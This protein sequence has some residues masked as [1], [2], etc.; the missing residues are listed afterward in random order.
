MSVV[1]PGEPRCPSEESIVAFVGGHLDALASSRIEVHVDACAACRRQL[2]EAGRALV[3]SAAAAPPDAGP[4]PLPAASEG[5]PPAR[6]RPGDRVGRYL[7]LDVLGEGAMGVVFSALDPELARH[8]ALKLVRVAH[9]HGA[10]REEHEARLIREAQ[11]M[12]RLSHPNVVRVYDIGAVASG[13]WIAMEHVR[14]QTLRAWLAAEPRPWRVALAAFLQAGDGLAAAHA[15]D[16]VH[17]DFKPDNVLVAD[18]G[19]VLVTDF[20]LA[21]V[22]E[23]EL[24]GAGAGLTTSDLTRTRAGTLVGTPAYMAPEQLSAHA[25]EVD[26]RADVFAFGVALYEALFGERPY[27]AT[28]LGELERALARGVPREPPRRSEVPRWVRRA[29][30]SALVADRERRV[31]SMSALLHALRAD[32]RRR[33]VRVVLPVT[34]LVVLAGGVALAQHLASAPGRACRASVERADGVWGSE[35]RAAGRAAFTATGLVYADEA[36]TRASA[37]LDD[38]LGAW[39]RERVAACDATH[40]QA[41]QSEALLDLRLH[42]LDQRLDEARALADAFTR[43]DATTVQ[44]ASEAVARLAESAICG[45]LERLRARVPPPTDPDASALVD[46]AEA[47]LAEAEIA[48]LTGD[49]ARGMSLAKE[50][51]ALAEQAAHTPTVAAAT[52]LLAR[53]TRSSGDAIGAMPLFGDAIWSAVAAGD[54]RVAANAAVQF[55]RSKLEI[56]HDRDESLGWS[57]LAEAHIARLGGDAT[58]NLQLLATR[59]KLILEPGDAADRLIAG[60]EDAIAE[61]AQVPSPTLDAALL[62]GLMGIGTLCREIECFSRAVTALEQ[63]VAHAD[64]HLGPLHPGTLAAKIELG[65]T[66]STAGRYAPASALLSSLQADLGRVYPEGHIDSAVLLDGLGRAMVGLG[67]FD[68]ATAA[69]EAEVA[70][71]GKVLGG[72]LGVLAFAYQ[73]HAR[74]SIGAGRGDAALIAIARA[75]SYTTK[76]LGDDATVRRTSATLRALALEA[77][78]RFDE[79]RAAF[80]ALEADVRGGLRSELAAVLGGMGRSDARAGRLEQAIARQREALA[81]RESVYGFDNPEIVIALRDLGAVYLDAGR[82]DEA[83]QALERGLGI[84]DAAPHDPL[85]EGELSAHLAGVVRASDPTRAESLL[86]AAERIAVASVYPRGARLARLVAARRAP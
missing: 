22:A 70:E 33:L 20:G 19:R 47:L 82:L 73:S 52:L 80:E 42:C 26:H 39:R 81:L 13:V 2:L 84:L 61:R 86:R 57:R 85:L 31:R 15:A 76:F 12:A 53:A 66:L 50:A 41:T 32:P 77:A 67:R 59:A 7:I 48:D 18:D 5:P 64:P 16:I 63:A 4:A 38:H 79:A 1:G 62:D 3:E 44:R 24:P 28:T 37:A 60:L 72:E 27:A 65:L 14:G 78:E 51:L 58:L 10:G 54:D 11:A 40:D 8:V 25:G 21:R 49:A 83:R 17:R 55:S 43:A 6:L 9:H 69:H 23:V 68:E 71:F 74:A 75:E 29:V 46:R 30:M 56:T 36:F 34:A 45:E 35:R